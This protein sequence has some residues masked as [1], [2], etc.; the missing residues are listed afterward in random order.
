MALGVLLLR[1]GE[2]VGLAGSPPRPGKAQVMTL[3]K[4]LADGTEDYGRPEVSGMANHGR[5]VFLSDF[6]GPLEGLETALSAA[7]DRGVRGVL[8]QV[9]D[10]AEEEFPFQGR[11]VF[12]SMGGGLTHETQSADAL[13]ERYLAR[14]TERKERLA[15][16]ARA[17]G[18]HYDCH[19][20]GAPAQ[21]ALLWAYRA[22]EG[23]R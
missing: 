6:L 5:A 11:T 1:G 18:W 3:V 12:E 20:S 22:L 23:G 10:P 19:H 4:G 8:L 7:S 21:A 16:L 15:T 17:V 9:L 14:L 13:R 2:R